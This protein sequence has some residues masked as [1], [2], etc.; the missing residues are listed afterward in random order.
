MIIRDALRR[1]GE[2]EKNTVRAGLEN[3]PEHIEDAETTLRRSMRLHPH[4]GTLANS[5]P[6]DDQ[7]K[8]A[9]GPVRRR[10][11]VSI[12][13]K[14]VDDNDDLDEEPMKRRSA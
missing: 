1:T 11:I 2:E 4:S 9:A 14:D 10:P 13:G 7:T 6:H 3:P 12:H 5:H 8:E